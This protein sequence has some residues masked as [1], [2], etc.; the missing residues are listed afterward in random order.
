MQEAD[1]KHFSDADAKATAG[2]IEAIFTIVIRKSL[3]NPKPKTMSSG[4]FWPR[5]SGPIFIGNETCPYLALGSACDAFGLLAAPPERHLE[6]PPQR[7]HRAE[8]TPYPSRIPLRTYRA[9]FREDA[10]AAEVLRGAR[11]FLRT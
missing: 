6:T 11:Y 8:L 10:S 1:W 7:L 2:K 5:S 9:G 4:R 3:T